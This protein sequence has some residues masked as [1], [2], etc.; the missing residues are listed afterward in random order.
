[1]SKFT[2]FLNLF[3]WDSVEDAE[4]EFDID[5]E[6][7]DNW[8]KIDT[9]LKEHISN[10]NTNL[11]N[12][13]KTTNDAISTKANSSDVYD[14]TEINEKM[15][16]KAN[17][18]DVYTK[19]ETDTKLKAKANTSD[20]YTKTELDT[21]INA[22]QDK[23]IA[24]TNI[25]I[26]NNTISA[27][28]TTSTTYSTATSSADGLMSKTDKSKLDNIFNSIYPVGSIYMSV[29]STNPANL[30]GGTWEQIKGRF[31][32]GTGSLESNNNDHFGQ[33]TAGEINAP[34][35]E[36]GGETWHKLTIN[37]MPKHKHN[38][39]VRINWY[40][41]SGY[42]PIFNQGDSNVGV[43]RETC[44]TDEVGGDNSHNNIPPYFA[45]NIWQ[46]TA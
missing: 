11:S 20:V 28:S 6:L 13:K 25:T 2:E 7:N 9:K 19:T 26:L 3:K 27:K 12:L 21:K 35:G 8:D 18:S 38:T 41:S 24:G 42:G 39:N 15:N 16:A 45:V 37:E 33:V 36:T 10:I 40:N 14:K 5:K 43:D 23:L 34:V 32:L 31:L 22:K 46:R 44:Y 4:E 17:S 1:M 29:N 30:F